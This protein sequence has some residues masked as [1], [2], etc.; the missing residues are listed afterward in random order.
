MA[1]QGTWRRGYQGT[2]GSRGE[3]P[4]LSR[5]LEKYVA[6]G[7]VSSCHVI[8]VLAAAIN[9]VQRAAASTIAATNA[10]D[11]AAGDTVTWPSLNRAYALRQRCIPAR[12]KLLK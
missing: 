7:S 10:K 6:T 8:A 1:D 12:S 5:S 3:W 4:K 2:S 11:A 9:H